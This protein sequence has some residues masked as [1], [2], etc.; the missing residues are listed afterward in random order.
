MRIILCVTNDIITDQRVNRIALSLKK[1]PADI[2]IVGVRRLKGLSPGISGIRTHR[3]RR[4]FFRGPLFYLEYNIRL[5]LF[6][7]KTRADIIV[8]NDLDTLP[9][10][11]LASVIKRRVLVYDSHEYFTEV[12]ELVDR[13][14]VR[15]IWQR[16]EKLILPKVKYAYTV[17]D[18]IAS[19]YEREYGISMKVIR[20][21]PFR[22]TKVQND[23]SLRTGNEKIIIYQ[24]ALN[25]GRGL[26][27]AIG[28]MKYT[29]N[30]KLVIAGGGDLETELKALAGSLNL[31]NKV[32]FLGIVPPD[33]LVKFTAQADMG[34]SLEENKGLNYYYALPNKLF[35]YIQ[36][37]IPVLVSDLPEMSAIV[38]RYGIGRVV[39]T[40]D[41]CELSAV[42]TEM[43]SDGTIIAKWKQNLETAAAKLCWE[44]E[45]CKLL[46]IYHSIAKDHS[47]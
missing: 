42:F 17:S 11:C 41:P 46:E 21:M 37:R 45:E 23:N 3:F 26:E 39:K 15:N 31:G 14:T 30:C 43:M 10:A 7:L 19:A 12:P 22:I 24:G 13:R 6:L 1:L 2:T 35:D 29:E 36:A 44:N 34:I 38:K 9:A 25:M 27:L 33:Q 28:A 40:S 4:I 18:S 16:I 32:L 5:L 47:C 8:A 20:N